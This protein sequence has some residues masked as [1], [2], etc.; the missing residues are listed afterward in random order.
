M[1][2][3]IP[4]VARVVELQTASEKPLAIVLAGHNG[5]GKSTMWYEHVSSVLKIPLINADRMMLSL[6]PEVEPGHALPD[7]ATE[8]RDADASWMKVAQEG[9]QAFVAKAL[10]NK[11]PFAMETVFS[12]WQQQDDGTFA[13]KIDNIRDMQAAGYFV[14]LFFVGLASADLSVMR[15]ASRVASGGHSV[16]SETLYRRFPRTQTAISHALPVV[17]AAIL[18]DNSRDQE[19][20]FTV[21]RVQAGTDI[22]Y[23]WRQTANLP[24][25]AVQQWLQVV[26]PV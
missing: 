21:C 26:A 22:L 24:P 13:S 2:E 3:L 8:I 17:D 7:W 4:A 1:N 18:V 16:P 11:V 5:S 12:H 23:D 6:L 14:V 19:R 15:V 9:V 10:A 20:A 25:A